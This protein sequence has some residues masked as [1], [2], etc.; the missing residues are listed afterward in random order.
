MGFV[1]EGNRRSAAIGHELQLIEHFVQHGYVIEVED[2]ILGPIQYPSDAVAVDDY[3]ESQ[4]RRVT[5]KT[6]LDLEYL[7]FDH[8]AE[9][10]SATGTA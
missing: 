4:T 8:E 9:R 2:N 7:D 1:R 3:D 10:L 5:D 6:E